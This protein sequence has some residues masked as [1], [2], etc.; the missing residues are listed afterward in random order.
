MNILT[1]IPTLLSILGDLP[2][3]LAALMSLKQAIVDAEATGKSGPDKLTAVLND[4]EAALNDLNPAWGGEF[5]P[6]AAEAEAVV[7]DIVGFYNAFAH[8]APA[9]PAA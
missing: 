8:A 9:K 2:K 7:N 3:V 6:I 1:F 5:A 4:F